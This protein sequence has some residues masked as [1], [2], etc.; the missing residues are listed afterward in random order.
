MA[1]EDIKDDVRQYVSVVTEDEGRGFMAT[2][3]AMTKVELRDQIMSDAF[4]DMEKFKTRYSRMQRL[5]KVIRAIN[6]TLA[7]N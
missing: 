1:L 5:S 3:E 6:V 4:R 7:A 2:V